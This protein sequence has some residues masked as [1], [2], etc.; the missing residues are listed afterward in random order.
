[1]E[2]RKSSTGKWTKA[3][4]ALVLVLIILIIALYFFSAYFA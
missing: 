3:Y 4:V 1:M 2:M